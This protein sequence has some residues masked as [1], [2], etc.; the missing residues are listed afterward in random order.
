M[1]T[2]MHIYLYKYVYKYVY[3]CITSQYAR[4]EAPVAMILLVAVGTSE[5]PPPP[6]LAKA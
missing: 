5:L 3:I 1:Y 6:N 4:P 2:C